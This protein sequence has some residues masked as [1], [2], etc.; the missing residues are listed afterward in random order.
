MFVAIISFP[1]IKEGKEREFEAWFAWS[2][3][4]FAR[5]KGFI[6]RLLLK[7]LQGGAYTAILE[8]ESK[9]TFTAMQQSAFHAEAGKRVAPLLDGSPQPQFFEVVVA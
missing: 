7:P 9:E 1:A 4:G 2:N 3:N 5:E 6:R 8:H